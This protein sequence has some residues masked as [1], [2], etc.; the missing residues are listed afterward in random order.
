[1]GFGQDAIKYEQKAINGENTRKSCEVNV[2]SGLNAIKSGQKAIN[3]ENTRKSCE[4]NMGSGQNAIKSGQKAITG[5]NTI[6]A[7]VDDPRLVK[8][9]EG[10]VEVFDKDSLPPMDTEPMV[11]KLKE[12]YVPKSIYVP[13]KVPYARREDEI[14]EI[15]KL[16]SDGIIEPVRDRP[17][18]ICSPTI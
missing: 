5:K 15:R 11:I 7:E 13:R 8:I 10:Y 2:G 6:K 14:N 12:N 3:G 18:E 1:M 17:T 9:V 16:E 4:F